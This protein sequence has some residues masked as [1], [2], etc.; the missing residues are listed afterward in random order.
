MISRRSEI[1]SSISQGERSLKYILEERANVLA[2]ETG[3]IERQRK[4]SGADRLANAG[5][6]LAESSRCEFGDGS[7]GGR[8][9]GGKWDRYGGAHTLHPKWRRLPRTT[10]WGDAT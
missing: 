4:C 9:A 7:I 3:C 10:S 2:R 5:L 1:V 6:W 8:T